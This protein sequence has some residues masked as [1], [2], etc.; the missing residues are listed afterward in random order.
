MNGEPTDD[1][2]VIARILAR[3]LETLERGFSDPYSMKQ[4]EATEARHALLDMIER[5]EASGEQPS[6]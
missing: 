4:N 5:R 2:A 3:V 6:T 1:V